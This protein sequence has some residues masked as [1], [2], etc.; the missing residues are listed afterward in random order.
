MS[1]DFAAHLLG[2]IVTRV[3]TE[4]DVRA[5]AREDV[6][7]GRTDAARST[8]DER[9]FSLKQKAHVAMCLLN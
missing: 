8:G 7:H 1:F 3:V 6:A 4:S 5:F 2:Q 9:A